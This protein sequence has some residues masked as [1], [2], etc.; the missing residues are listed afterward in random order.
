MIRNALLA[1]WFL[2]FSFLLFRASRSVSA[3]SGRLEALRETSRRLDEDSREL[4]DIS[5]KI[6]AREKEMGSLLKIVNLMPEDR[7][8]LRTQKVV[9]DEVHVLRRKA[10]KWIGPSIGCILVD[11]KAN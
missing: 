8:F 7:G 6:R 9:S 2:A 1:A 10:R 11:T 3:F 4:A 5:R